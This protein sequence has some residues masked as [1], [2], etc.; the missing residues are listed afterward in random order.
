MDQ[1]SQINSGV[2][3]V[4]QKYLNA[5]GNFIMKTYKGMLEDL[6]FPFLKLLFKDL[7]LVKAISAI[8]ESK[9][10]TGLERME[11]EK[12]VYIIGKGYA[13]SSSNYIQKA[14][15]IKEEYRAALTDDKKKKEFIKKGAKEMEQLTKLLKEKGIERTLPINSS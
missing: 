5:S 6:V 3:K 15:Q 9:P 12:E 4:C 8:S 7:M 13:L 11:Q 10:K 2:I 1:M 14:A